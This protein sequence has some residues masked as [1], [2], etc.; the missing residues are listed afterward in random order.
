L[1]FLSGSGKRETEQGRKQ[2]Y[3]MA[4]NAISNAHGCS[5]WFSQLVSANSV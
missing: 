1:S 2:N 4:A 5:S 3:S